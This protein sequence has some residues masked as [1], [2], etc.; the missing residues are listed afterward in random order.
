VN[1]E[2]NQRPLGG[3]RTEKK[4]PKVIGNF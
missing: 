1:E 4:N 2:K 3:Y